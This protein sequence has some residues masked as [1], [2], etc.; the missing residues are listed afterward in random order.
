MRAPEEDEIL[1]Q[2]PVVFESVLLISEVLLVDKAFILLPVEASER[3]IPSIVT[4]AVFV[5]FTASMMGLFVLHVAP[6]P[7]TVIG[8]PRDP[9]IPLSMSASFHV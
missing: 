3:L 8:S 5:R 6:Y 7:F 4:Y 1:I 9:F 2:I